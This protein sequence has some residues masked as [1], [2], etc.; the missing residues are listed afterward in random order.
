MR[1]L[2]VASI[3]EFY[4]G[5]IF[6]ANCKLNFFNLM[7]KISDHCPYISDQELELLIPD[8]EERKEY[9]LKMLKPI[10]INYQIS[11]QIV[12]M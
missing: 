4:S 7:S 6:E 1:L 8:S 3:F 2:G 11:N 9:S 10:R 5:N 12:L